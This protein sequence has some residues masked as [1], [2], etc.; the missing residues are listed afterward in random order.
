M[1]AVG[2]EGSV[3]VRAAWYE[4]KG[5]AKEVNVVGETPDPKPERG[6]VRIRISASGINPGD[7]KARQDTF[8]GEMSFPRVI[9]RSDSAGIIDQVVSV[10]RS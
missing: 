6:E 5:P 8:G 1:V 2:G 10:T 9:P 7:I 4:K 3:E